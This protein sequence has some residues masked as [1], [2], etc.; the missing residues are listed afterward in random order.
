MWVCAGF[1]G[2]V[3]SCFEIA[4]SSSNLWWPDEGEWTPMAACGE[5]AAAEWP[6]LQAA[7]EGA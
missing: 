4:E 5:A 7:R 1:Y 6:K 3:G 2:A